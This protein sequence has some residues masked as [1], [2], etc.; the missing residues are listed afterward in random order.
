MRFGYR[1]SA[2][3]GFARAA[4]LPIREVADDRL[5]QAGPAGH[6]GGEEQVDLVWVKWPSVVV[7]LCGMTAKQRDLCCLGVV[8]DAFGHGVQVQDLAQADD[9][10]GDGGA[11]RGAVEFSDEATVEF[12]D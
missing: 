12:Q 5:G 10:L 8:F 6:G 1:V 11:L 3:D 4:G 7:A 9:G 2:A